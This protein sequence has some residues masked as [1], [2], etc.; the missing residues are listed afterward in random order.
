MNINNLKEEL[1]QIRKQISGITGALKEYEDIKPGKLVMKKSNGCYQ[2][3]VRN[4]D[5]DM[6]YIPAKD[7]FIVNQ[8]AQKEY[9]EKLL[10]ELKKQ[11]TCIARFIGV[12][13]KSVIW[14]TYEGICDGRKRIIS[15]VTES[16]DDY[17]SNWLEMHKG[18]QNQ[19]EAKELFETNRGDLVRSKS[20]KIIADLFY[21]YKVPYQYE[22]ELILYNGQKCYPDFVL[23]NKRER[24]TYF[25]EH[26]GLVS[27]DGYANNN[28][29]KIA[30]YEKSGMVLGEN[31]LMSMESKNINLDIQKVRQKI[32]QYLL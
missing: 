6:S 10:K 12:Y 21:E 1:N 17:I 9:Y 7:R 22:P 15:P 2:Y 28:L 18:N 29:E 13:S 23:L 31:L 32:E 30:K 26:F 16:Q 14:D 3:Y 8:M 4:K 19:F 5:G 20:E 24:K 27:D 25:W 11:E